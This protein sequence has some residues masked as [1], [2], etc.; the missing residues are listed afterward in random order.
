MASDANEHANTFKRLLRPHITSLTIGVVAVVIEG[1][2]NLAE[3]W[4]LKIVLDAVMKAKSE[5][6]WLHQMIG[7]AI[8]T[9]RITIVKFAALAVLAIAG[10]GAVSNYTER[11]LTTS[12]S[13]YVI[14]DLRQKLYSHIQRLSLNYHDRKCTGDLISRL[15]SDIDSIQ[16]FIA[17][18]LLGALISTLTL[19]G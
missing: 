7:S 18:G 6:G 17:S 2:A 9:D 1:L 5:H 4:P 19:A 14:Y 16:S 13:Q 10:V 8:G 12:I 11:Y 15:T 3:P